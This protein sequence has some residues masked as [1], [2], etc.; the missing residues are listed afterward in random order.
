MLNVLYE[1]NHLLVV[2]KPAGLATVG[3]ADDEPSL[4]KHAKQYLKQ[5]YAKPGNVFLG[6]VS[7]LDLLVTGIV[8]F[9]RT[10]KA[11]ARLSEQFRSRSVE[12]Q[13]LAI[14]AGTPPTGE[15]T[16]TDWVLKND[17]RHRME[18]V[19]AGTPQATHA[20]L[21]YQVLQSRPAVSLVSVELITGRKHQIR[22]QLSHAGYP[23]LG[24]IKYGSQQV[25]SPGI[26]LHAWQLQFDH[27]TRDERIPLT[28]PPPPAWQKYGFDLTKLQ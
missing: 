5:K 21:H 22:L 2:A 14:V 1:D 6:V 23:I 3:V 20:E 18:V 10:S 27:P 12:K 19:P 17:A 11:A 28:L 25:F 4:A 15:Q 8:V 26:A 24:D 16:L 13:Y 9:A 7:R